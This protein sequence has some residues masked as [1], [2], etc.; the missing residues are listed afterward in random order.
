MARA[1][2]T[3]VNPDSGEEITWLRVDDDVLEWE[4]TWPPGHR[5][6]PHVHPGMEESW[7]VLEGEP[8]FRIGDGPDRLLGPGQ[9]IVAPAGVAHGGWNP[10]DKPVRLRVTMIPPLRWAEVAEKLFAG[11]PP[12]ELLRDHPAELAPPSR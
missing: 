6:L 11:T 2:E 12:L 3:I 9:T 5:V 4:D 1:G 8:A 7:L 10:T